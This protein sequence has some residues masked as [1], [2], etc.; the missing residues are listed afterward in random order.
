MVQ[1]A[2]LKA[3]REGVEIVR[4]CSDE[5]LRV[6]YHLNC[7]THRKHGLPPQPFS[8]F[9]N[10]FDV[11]KTENRLILLLAKINQVN[12]AAGIFVTHGTR[13]Y[14][15]YGASDERYLRLRANQLLMWNLIKW[16]VENNYALID[17]GRASIDNKGLRDYKKRWNSSENPLYYYYFPEIK[18]VGSINRKQRKVRLLT[19][20]WKH[21]PI[22]LIKKTAFLYKHLA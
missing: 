5:A 20:V 2:I 10:M 3:E 15:L 17:M 21:I 14:Y 11:F 8:Y 6:F 9:Q 16:G 7:L 1:R 4:D 12:I 22:S 18:G 19:S 13:I